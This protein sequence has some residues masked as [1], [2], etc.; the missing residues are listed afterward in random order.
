MRCRHVSE[1]EISEQ[2][3]K[4]PPSGVT[5]EA[6]SRP[7]Q[8]DVLSLLLAVTGDA[9]LHLEAD[10]KLALPVLSHIRVMPKT[11]HHNTALNR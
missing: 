1:G 6:W 8:E 2:Q 7:L 4:N 11:L 10:V 3:K 9:S 5:G